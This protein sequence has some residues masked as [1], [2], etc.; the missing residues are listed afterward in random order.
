MSFGKEED[1]YREKQARKSC[2]EP[3]NSVSDKSYKSFMVKHPTLR[4]NLETFTI[5][6]CM[7]IYM[8]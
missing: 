1:N 2:E 7:Y 6:F 4:L 3:L 8:F 5:L